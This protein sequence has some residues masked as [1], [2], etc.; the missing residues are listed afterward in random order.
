MAVGVTTARDAACKR[1]VAVNMAAS[2]TRE[3]YGGEEV[4]VVDGDP[5]SRDVT[6]RLAVRGANLDDFAAAFAP[7]IDAIG[8]FDASDFHFRVLGNA[9]AGLG[10]LRFAAERAKP[11]LAGAFDVVIWDLVGGPNG[12]GR[13]VGESLDMLDWLLLAVT[14]APGAVAAAQNFLEHFETARKRGVIGRRLRLG[15]VCTGDEGC[16]QYDTDE[17]A[18]QLGIEVIGS[19]PQ[20]WGRAE[21]NLGFGPALAIPEL[22]D[23][24]IDVFSA[25][26][27]SV[28]SDRQRERVTF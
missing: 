20:L 2:L 23:A 26:W 28:E 4:C 14:P 18:S 22:D 19:I 3:L 21:P 12:P 13:V 9:G 25:L 16:T 15:V 7:D 17:V 1:G 27:S 11:V 24:V 6:T 5:L 10:R 8:R